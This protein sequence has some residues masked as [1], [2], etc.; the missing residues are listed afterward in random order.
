[1]MHIQSAHTRA[2][3]AFL[4]MVVIVVSAFSLAA[5]SGASTAGTPTGTP[6]ASAQASPTPISLPVHTFTLDNFL[7]DAVYPN[8][9]GLLLSGS[10]PVLPTKRLEGAVVGVSLPPRSTFTIS[11]PIR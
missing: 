6:V 11:L 5:C 4:I 2:Y 8:Q 3:H 7:A 1:M 9:D 10:P